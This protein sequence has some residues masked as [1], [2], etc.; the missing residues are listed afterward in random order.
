MRLWEAYTDT[1]A[2]PG[3]AGGRG[4]LESKDHHRLILKTLHPAGTRRA[5]NSGARS[6]VKF[7]DRPEKKAPGT[8]RR[9]GQH[10]S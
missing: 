5:V 1:G 2:S 8:Q 7:I 10:G 6:E 4:E 3:R 9:R